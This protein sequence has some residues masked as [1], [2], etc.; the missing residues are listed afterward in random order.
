MSTTHRLDQFAE[1]QAKTSPKRGS[2]LAL[3]LPLNV[4]HGVEH[5]HH[6]WSEV[7]CHYVI[8]A[9]HHQ[10]VI[11]VDDVLKTQ[12]Q[13]ELTPLTADKVLGEQHQDLPTARHAAHDVVHNVVA[14]R[15]KDQLH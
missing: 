10:R 5:R 8:Q 15:R 4:G 12:G 13:F 7:T 11:V 3:V 6:W 2:G 1:R 9:N 14:C